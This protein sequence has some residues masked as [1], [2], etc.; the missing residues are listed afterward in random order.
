MTFVC[1]AI[2]IVSQFTGV[3]FSLS[4][5]MFALSVHKEFTRRF[6][7]LGRKVH[8]VSLPHLTNRNS[9]YAFQTTNEKH[10][11]PLLRMLQNGLLQRPGIQSLCIDIATTNLK[12]AF[13]NR[14]LTEL[15]IASKQQQRC[16]PTHI[17]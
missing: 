13:K 17:V 9:I 16:N 6:G 5:A 4:D 12:N 15:L 1:H 8:K 10:L 3:Y 14:I 2:K 11:L 7:L